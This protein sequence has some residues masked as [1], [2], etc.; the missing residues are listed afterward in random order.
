MAVALSVLSVIL[1]L[2]LSSASEASASEAET[3]TITL[4][5]G[6]NFVGWVA[7][8]TLVAEIF[9]EIP[10]AHLIYRWDAD[11]GAYQFASRDDG[12]NLETLHP[13]MAAKIRIGG[14]RAVKWEQALTPATGA[15]T[16][17]SGI[18][19][20]AWNGRDDWPLDELA[21]GI[22]T[23]LVSIEVRGQVYQPGSHVSEVVGPLAGEA[24]IRRG[25]ALRVTVNRDLRWLQPTGIMPKIAW[26]GDPPQS[27]RD[28]IL[29]DIQ[30]VVDFFADEFAI[31]G[32]FSDTTIVLFDLVADA[33]AYEE[34]GQE[35]RFGT[36]PGWV[37]ANLP[38]LGAPAF[39]WG[40]FVP[41]CAWQPPC[42]E[43]DESFEKGIQLLAHEMFHLL[44]FQL[45]QS[46]RL[47][48]TPDWMDE[49]SAMWAEWRVPAEFH[50]PQRV[51]YDD[52]LQWR[53]DSAAR[54]TVRLQEIEQH[55]HNWAYTLGHLATRQLAE[56]SG[57]V[58]VVEF[59]RLMHP[60]S[61]GT[62]QSWVRR[63]DWQPQFAAAF[64]FTASEFYDQFAA[65]RETL[66]VPAER[67]DYDQGDVSLAG[68][69]HYSTGDPAAGFSLNA[70]SPPG[71]PRSGI[72]RRTSV[73]EEGVFSIELPPETK[74][75]IWFTRGGC[76]L[77]LTDDGLTTASPQAGQHRDIDTRS[78]PEL[79]LT[80]PDGAC[81][82]ELRLTV[83]PLRGDERFVE[84]NLNSEDGRSWTTIASGPSGRYSGFAPEPGKYRV[85]TYLAGCNLW[86]HE[87][88]LV[89]S[90]SAGQL[91]PLGENPVLIEL[92][93]PDDLCVHNVSGHLLDKDGAAVEG[94]NL[95][96]GA[97]DIAGNGRTA[98]DGSF[99]ITVPDSGDYGLSFWSEAGSCRIYYSTNGATDDWSSATPITVGDED[100][101]S[102][103]FV[104]PADPSSLCN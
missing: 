75:R 81:E 87:D 52:Y 38:H 70:S 80:L 7:E 78:L 5:P 29:L 13:G 50:T 76:T 3:R 43:R 45:T 11:S 10:Q 53:I 95:Y 97:G 46:E 62:E 66:P 35:P 49:G 83:L 39:P 48:A 91:L 31:E 34:S 100:V 67:Y 71:E 68:T 69:L 37:A 65:W 41:I 94:V 84:L 79:N 4:Q 32:D 92:R 93:I 99:T 44:Q 36:P 89:A 102:I 22:G 12:G 33:V 72:E 85:R 56:L 61:V 96:M 9:E 20:V 82:N 59:Y 73:N 58:S 27:L 55:S 6:D 28:E 2:A 14:K 24:V 30:R 54:T 15:V 90:W 19:W 42:R 23:S 64:G 16:L 26:A 8:A 17:Y 104:V 74:Q 88:G 103:E 57:V 51:G 21:R 98:A 40:T 63:P 101:T 25:D 47:A 1:A 18:N 60:Q 86:Y 77:W